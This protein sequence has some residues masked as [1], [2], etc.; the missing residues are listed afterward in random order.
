MDREFFIA[1][2]ER[3]VIPGK[4][5]SIK[6]NFEAKLNDNLKGF[7]RSKFEVKRGS[8]GLVREWNIPAQ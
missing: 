6:I 3:S 7:Y 8:R 4:N 5:Y 1:N 2:L